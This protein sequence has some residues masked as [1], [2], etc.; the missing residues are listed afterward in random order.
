[1][2]I[3]CCEVETSTP[4][5]IEDIYSR[6]ALG[7]QR[8]QEYNDREEGLLAVYKRCRESLLEKISLGGEEIDLILLKHFE[9]AIASDEDLSVDL[10]GIVTQQEKEK[11]YLEPIEVMRSIAQSH[12]VPFPKNEELMRRLLLV[13]SVS[14]RNVAIQE[15]NEMGGDALAMTLP[16]KLCLVNAQSDELGR[17]QAT[18]KRRLRAIGIHELW[19]S[20]DYQEVWQNRSDPDNP[21]TNLVRRGGIFVRSCDQHGGEGTSG[22]AALNE[23]FASFRTR[24]TLRLLGDRKPFKDEYGD[25]RGVIRLLINRAGATP[26]YRAAGTKKGLQDLD[27]LLSVRYGSN[28][29]IQIATKMADETGL[30]RMQRWLQ[31]PLSPYPETRKFIRR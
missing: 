14:Y 10:S 23:G 1:M 31:R 2:I 8:M 27:D 4:G 11:I 12:D 26:F 6:R 16:N 28:A 18:R 7:I 22:F 19:H 5:T 3:A 17:S 9:E 24:E 29:L 21:E 30:R 15:V 20:V 25:Q 13:D